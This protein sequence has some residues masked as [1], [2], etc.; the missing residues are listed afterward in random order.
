MRQVEIVVR[1]GPPPLALV[2]LDMGSGRRIG[3]LK[4]LDF[5]MVMGN[6]TACAKMSY[7]GLEGSPDGTVP[8][9]HPERVV[10]AVDEN[11]ATELVEEDVEVVRFA[12]HP[13]AERPRRP[14]PESA[15]SQG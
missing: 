7:L 5:K 11:G 3:L 1:D 6:G 2:V 14:A 8:P 13:R 15:T 4:S 12:T 9:D 10:A